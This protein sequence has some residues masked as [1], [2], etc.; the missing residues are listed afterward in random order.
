MGGLVA[1]ERVPGK[2]PRALRRRFSSPPTAVMP[3]PERS[4][5]RTPNGPTGR[6]PRWKRRGTPCGQLTAR[7]EPA[8]LVAMVRGGK[9]SLDDTLVIG[10]EGRR[11][12]ARRR[13]LYTAYPGEK[14][15]LSGGRKVTGW[16]P[17]KDQ[18][19]V[20]D[21]PGSKGGKWKFRRLWADG[22]LQ[23]RSRWPNFDPRNPVA[24]RLGEGRGAGRARQP[25]GVSLPAGH[26]SAALGQAHRGR[27]QYLLRQFRLLL[28]QRRDPH[29]EHRRNE[30]HHHAY[31]ADAGFRLPLVVLGHP[32]PSGCPVYWSRTCWKSSI[33]RASGAWTARKGS[34]I[35]GRRAARSRAWKI[36]APKLGRLVALHRTGFVTIRGFTFT[37]TTDGDEP[38][39]GGVEGLGAMFSMSAD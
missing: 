16:Q 38:Q 4:P 36:V 37:E 25:A 29:Q 1:A 17:Y 8:P 21:L 5:R 15:I 30:T 13:L 20:C 6:S 24:R 11:H 3:G 7:G 31:A 32:L 22:K 35:T 23:C 10:P 2:S 14:P 39:P 28:G 12:R 34:S 19:F 27:S 9:Y 33:S 18:I 26:V